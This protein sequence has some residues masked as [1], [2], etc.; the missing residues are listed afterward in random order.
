MGSQRVGHDW[1][2]FSFAFHI[3]GPSTHLRQRVAPV[4][5]A[6]PPGLCQPYSSF[7]NVW[8]S[9]RGWEMLLLQRVLSCSPDWCPHDK[10]STGLGGCGSSFKSYSKVPPHPPGQS[11]SWEPQGWGQ[12]KMMELTDPKWGYQRGLVMPI[13]LTNSHTRI[14]AKSLALSHYV[15]L[16]FPHSH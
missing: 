11:G 1:E 15:F 13:R 14:S 10:A 7:Q 6:G 2:T 16:P 8:W 5:W 4:H 9:G 3:Q 12:D